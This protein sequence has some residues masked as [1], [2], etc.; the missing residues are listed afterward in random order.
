F[1]LI[2]VTKAVPLQALSRSYISHKLFSIL[3]KNQGTVPA[4]FK[5]RMKRD[6]L[7]VMFTCLILCKYVDALFSPI[8]KCS[9]CY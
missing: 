2:H 9:F 6:F 3:H 1:C 5:F 8:I 4:F 7:L